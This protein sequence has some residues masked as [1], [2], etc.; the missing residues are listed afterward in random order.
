MTPAATTG[1]ASTIGAPEAGPR[2]GQPGRKRSARS[3]KRI[4]DC[5]VAELE[6][7][8]YYELTIEGVAQAAGVSKATIYRWWPSKPSL[9]AEA[10]ASSLDHDMAPETDD[11]ER[12][13]LAAI[14][15]TID[16]FGG[17]LGGIAL[18]AL[19]ADLAHDAAGY[20]AFYEG[21][22]KPR[23]AASAA[24]IRRAIDEGLL[25]PDT[26]AELTLDLWAG[27]VFYRILI[28]RQPVTDQFAEEILKHLR[29][30]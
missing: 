16:N 29:C 11:V 12:D 15:T 6:R 2:A 20:R 21:F 19:V 3:H 7:V 1:Q 4:V 8:G 10:I 13:L 22:L 9:V 18:P 23:R 5:T 27:A 17:S 14:Q 26:D 28:S 25:A 24:V 30:T